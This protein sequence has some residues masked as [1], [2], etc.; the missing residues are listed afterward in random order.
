M[1]HHKIE[2]ILHDIAHASQD[3]E[4]TQQNIEYASQD[5]AHTSQDIEYKS[6]DNKAAFY[7]PYPSAFGVDVDFNF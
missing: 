3:I 5:S 2:Y 7:T 4:Q 6:Q 1:I